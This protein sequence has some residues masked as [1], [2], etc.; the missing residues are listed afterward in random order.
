MDILNKLV[1]FI[2]SIVQKIKDFVA[3]IRHGNDTGW[4]TEDETTEAAVVA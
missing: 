1:A 4:K 3:A 2:Q